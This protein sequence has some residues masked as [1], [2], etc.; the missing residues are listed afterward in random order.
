MSC[1]HTVALKHFAV[2]YIM[3]ST[4]GNLYFR[5]ILAAA[6]DIEE[7]RSTKRQLHTK[8]LVLTAAL[9]DLPKRNRLD[10]IATSKVIDGI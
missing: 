9:G 2:V 4:I 6:V 8:N 3:L 5:L 1:V 7:V 10:P